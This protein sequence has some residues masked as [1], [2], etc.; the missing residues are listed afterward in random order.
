MNGKDFKQSLKNPKNIYCLISTDSEM[1]DLY[2][3][4]FMEA[5]GITNISRGKIKPYGKLFKQKTLNILYMQKI[6]ESIFDRREYIF[7]Y[8]DSIDKRSSVY[9]KYKDQIIEIKNDY[10]DYVMKHSDFN[11][12]EAKDF[13]KQSNND[14]GIIKNNLALY[15]VSNKQYDRFTDYSNDIYSWVNAYIKKETL[16]RCTESPI[17]IM[18]LLSTN[19]NN[20]LKVKNKD[21]IGMNPYI[22]SCMMKLINYITEEELIQIIGDCFYLDCQIKKGLIDINDAIGY[23]ILRRYNSATTN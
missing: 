2:S 7:I 3:K 18:A 4:R 1:I 20:L 23:L 9:K 21:T 14:L 6:D 22:V 12:E 13:C 11:E 15:N 8:T 5:V 19:C 17:S 16:P 10:T